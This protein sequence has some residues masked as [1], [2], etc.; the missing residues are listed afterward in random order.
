MTEHSRMAQDSRIAMSLQRFETAQ[1][2]II[3]DQL[4]FKICHARSHQPS[5]RSP[6]QSTMSR[7]AARRRAR[8]HNYREKRVANFG[9]F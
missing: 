9:Q 3:I 1:L 4:R 8:K 2:Q 7:A 6:L 5:H